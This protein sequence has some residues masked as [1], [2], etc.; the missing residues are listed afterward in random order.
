MSTLVT[1]EDLWDCYPQ[2]LERSLR[3]SLPMLDVHMRR[4]S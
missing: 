4:F 2:P 3:K 1:R